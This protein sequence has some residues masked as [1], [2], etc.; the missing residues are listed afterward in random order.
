MGPCRAASVQILDCACIH[1]DVAAVKRLREG[2]GM[3]PFIRRR[4]RRYVICQ[5]GLSVKMAGSNYNIDCTRDLSFS[6][7]P[8]LYHLFNCRPLNDEEYRRFVWNF[9]E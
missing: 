6:F 5:G 1:F 2:R 7:S 4:S 9:G 8:S 3:Y